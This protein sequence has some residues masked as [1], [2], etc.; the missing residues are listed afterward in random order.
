MGLQ[1]L[2]LV[3]VL[4]LQLLLFHLQG[5][6]LLALQVGHVVRGGRRIGRSG[7]ALRRG[8]SPVGLV[9]PFVFLVVECG[10]SQDVKEKEGGSDGDGD[11][12][13]GGVV[14]LRLNN[15]C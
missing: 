2:T 8:N 14:P 15:H 7:I 1:G 10:K 4:V 5:H 3:M 6:Q 12:E 13:L 9:P 11:A